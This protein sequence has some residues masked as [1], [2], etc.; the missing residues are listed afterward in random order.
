MH[1][2]VARL[3]TKKQALSACH[4]ATSSKLETVGV[5]FP[6]PVSDARRL[7]A[8]AKNKSGVE[9]AQ[10]GRFQ[11]AIAEFDAAIQL[12]PKHIEAFTNRGSAYFE[13]GG[14]TCL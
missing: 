12:N 5:Q 6:E 3:I 1:V 2:L 11:D 9:I 4:A 8:E 10:E 13:M 14:Q 7:Q